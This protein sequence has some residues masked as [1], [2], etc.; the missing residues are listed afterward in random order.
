M[1]PAATIKEQRVAHAWDGPHYV[2]EV[3]SGWT[4]N[5]KLNL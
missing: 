2:E 4:S 3:M 5:I 1:R